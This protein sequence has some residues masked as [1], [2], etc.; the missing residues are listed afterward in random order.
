[1]HDPRDPRFYRLQKKAKA[2]LENLTCE[3]LREYLGYIDKM[4]E[5]VKSRISR[6]EWI[7]LKNGVETV[8]K[9]N[10]N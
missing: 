3:E 4:I 6:R 2:S 5:Y 1:M 8:L 7:A 10:D 9:L